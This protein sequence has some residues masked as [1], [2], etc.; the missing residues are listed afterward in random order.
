ML[1]PFLERVRARSPLIHNITNYV[2]ANDCANLL[3]S[4]GASPLMADDPQ[5]AAE[6]TR[7]C[8]GL[9]LNLGTLHT[10]TIPAMVAAGQAANAL[11]HPVVLDPVG[12]GASTLRTDTAHMLLEQVRFSVIRGNSSEVKTLALGRGHSHGVDASGADAVTPDTLGQTL[13]L[14]QAFARQ[15]GAVVVITGAMDLVAD[16]NRTFLLRNGHPFLGHVTGTGCMLSALIGAYVAASP[17]Q[18][19]EATA[20]AVC[21]MGVC[22]ELAFA[23][24]GPQDGNGSYKTYLLDALC[25][26]TGAELERRANYEV[27]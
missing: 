11:G 17:Q 6:M 19:L 25:H 8:D 5:E 3:L 21:A 18:V 27:R 12:V 15:S 1:S 2:T 13:A 9:V 10:H 4:C 26:L 22:G 14:A 16:A 23:R 20:A 24:M 7:G